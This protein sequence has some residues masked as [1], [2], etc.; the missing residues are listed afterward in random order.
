[1]TDAGQ[2]FMVQLQVVTVDVS[3][4]TFFRA[5]LKLVFMKQSC[6]TFVLPLM[7]TA[8]ANK[9]KTV[10]LQFEKN[11]CIN[12]QATKLALIAAVTLE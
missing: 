5:S 12:I 11:I 3:D 1:M 8:L 10:F 7:S 4:Q 2:G 6:H 9:I